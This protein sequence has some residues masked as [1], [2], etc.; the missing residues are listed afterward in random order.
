M[1][2]KPSVFELLRFDYISYIQRIWAI[3]LWL[4]VTST[5]KVSWNEIVII[6]KF[7]V[8]SNAGIKTAVCT[9]KQRRTA[10]EKPA[11]NGQKKKQ[12][13]DGIGAGGLKNGLQK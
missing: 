4:I 13:L 2:T 12:L 5:P 7:V 8:V 11:W 3:N 9:Y 10:N 1:V 6:T